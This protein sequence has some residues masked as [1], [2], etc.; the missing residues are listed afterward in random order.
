[1]AHP[2][3]GRLSTQVPP[4][5]CINLP[6][7]PRPPRMSSSPPRPRPKER[8]NTGL[9]QGKHLSCFLYKNPR[10]DQSE[11]L[12]P[13]TLSSHEP[14]REPGTLLGDW[15]ERLKDKMDTNRRRRSQSGE[16]MDTQVGDFRIL[17][18]KSVPLCATQ[19]ATLP[20]IPAHPAAFGPS[21]PLCSI[22]FLLFQGLLPDL[23]GSPLLK[24]KR[25]NFR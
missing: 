12:P 7:P 19:C 22:P 21:F 24:K 8:E 25:Q 16:K 10:L 17:E 23:T 6:P 4:L 5:G 15:E 11:E 13:F 2:C 3:R 18:A 14:L 20:L 9:L 1:M